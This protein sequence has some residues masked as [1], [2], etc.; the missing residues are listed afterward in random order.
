MLYCFDIH[1]HIKNLQLL[2]PTCWRYT[3]AL[4]LA[5]HCCGLS[6]IFERLTQKKPLRCCVFLAFCSYCWMSQGLVEGWVTALS[7]GVCLFD[8]LTACHVDL[9][10]DEFV[11]WTELGEGASWQTDCGESHSSFP[12]ENWLASCSDWQA[13]E[14]GLPTW[15]QR[16]HT[17]RLEN[18]HKA[19]L[20][21]NG[22]ATNNLKD[23]G[24]NT[25][26]HGFV[27]ACVCV[28]VLCCVDASFYF[29]IWSFI[30][31][32]FVKSVLIWALW[33]QSLIVFL[34]FKDD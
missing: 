8:E 28:W 12:L 30:V 25:Q 18:V 14:E 7:W 31:K 21:N 33:T 5:W 3:A 32:H 27:F 11:L 24:L 1:P 15:A 13:E 4:T 10:M 29:I 17:A 34:M 20:I 23:F 16:S 19:A 26:V 2:Q 9:A 6:Y 22:V